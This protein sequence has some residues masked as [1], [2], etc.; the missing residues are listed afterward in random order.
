VFKLSKL[1]LTITV[2]TCY[3]LL[4]GCGGGGGGGGSATATAPTVFG[5]DY[6]VNGNYQNLNTGY[7]GVL[8][9]TVPDA[10]G[11]QQTNSFVGNGAFSFTPDI[12]TGGSYN[13]VVNQNPPGYSCTVANG[14]GSNVTS[15]VTGVVVTCAY[16][17]PSFAMNVM[18]SGLGVGK[19]LVLTDNGTDTS[20]ITAN[21]AFTFPTRL[22][23]GVNWTVAIATQPLLQT[24]TMINY[25]GFS[26][27]Q[28]QTVTVTCV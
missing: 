5:I 9:N 22:V 26:I 14:T 27:A 19:S 18:V 2:I 12:S 11:V 28:D 24:C 3:A 25:S 16:V 23:Y 13:I 10:N 1:L 8:E 20:T 15:T 6:A 21:G 4:N 7:V 17:N